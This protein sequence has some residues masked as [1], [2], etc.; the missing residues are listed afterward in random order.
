VIID[1]TRRPALRY[2]P[3]ADMRERWPDWRFECRALPDADEAEAI[4]PDERLIEF[5]SQYFDDD[6]KLALAHGSR[7]WICIWT[8]CRSGSAT[9]SAWMLTFWLRSGWTGRGTGEDFGPA[10]HPGGFQNGAQLRQTRRHRLRHGT[11]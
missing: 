5:D 2:D 4:L 6:W 8:R 7:T 3:L 10:R 11:G 9:S 1:P